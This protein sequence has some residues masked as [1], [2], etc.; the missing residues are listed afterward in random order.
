MIKLR[1]NPGN[2]QSNKQFIADNLL[3]SRMRQDGLYSW[4]NPAQHKQCHANMAMRW[5][6]SFMGE[7][8]EYAM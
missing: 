8:T 5:R 2:W 7:K 3:C 1:T 6:S 4:E